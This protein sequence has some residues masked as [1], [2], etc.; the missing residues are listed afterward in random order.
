MQNEY[1]GAL[2]SLSA[3]KIE[4]KQAEKAAKEAKLAVYRKNKASFLKM[5]VYQ[6][7]VIWRKS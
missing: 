5:P 6:D 3:E 1:K 7:L 2:A 4:A